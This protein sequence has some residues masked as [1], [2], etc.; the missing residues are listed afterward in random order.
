MSRRYTTAELDAMEAQAVEQGMNPQAAKESSETLTGGLE[1]GE[2]FGGGF[3][4]S[5]KRTLL[6][7][8]Q[9][10]EYLVGDD[11]G[12]EKVNAAIRTLEEH[13][14]LQTPAGKLGEAAGTA[15]QF[16]GPQAVGGVVAKVVPKAIVKG[17]QA[18]TGAPGSTGRAALQGATYEAAQPITPSDASNDEY[19]L[20]K[21][22]MVATGAGGGAVA[23]KVG[24]FLTREGMPIPP[25]RQGMV[26]EAERLGIP[27]TP[28]ERTGNK[29]LGELELGYRSKAGSAPLILAPGEKRQEMLN[30]AG[31]KSIGSTE[32]APTEA[33]LA[34]QRELANKGY[35]PIA[36]IPKMSPDLTYFDDLDKLAAKQMK[37]AGG[38]ADVAG[39][40][41]RLKAGSAKITGNDFLQELQTVR[42]M[43]YDAKKNGQSATASQL[44]DLG[45]LMEDFAERRVEK[46]AKAGKIASDAMDRLKQARTDLSK[47]H[48][49]E[50]AV[51]PVT[52]QMS[53]NKY[54]RKE[55]Q[56]NPASA[57]PSQSPV[58]KG[59][60]DVGAIARVMRQTNPNNSSLGYGGLMAGRE[61]ASA[62]QGPG[63]FLLKAGPIAKNYL[64]AKYY[65]KYGGKPSALGEHLTPTQ[66][67]YVR[68]LLPGVGF[69]T[70]E[71]VAD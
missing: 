58:S 15:A 30:T 22:G 50:E 44:R 61:V 13:P 20:G 18:V 5:L 65:M 64:A 12:R 29:T 39:I 9:A 45:S 36:S 34:Q 27:L 33:V 6:G 67:D 7:L 59:L 32:E 47:I 4:A 56:R 24:K 25:A 40:I 43:S 26:T 23:G 68:R 19:L 11:A 63:S 21:T 46:L 35:E 57:G 62:T 66:N 37:R 70:K 14:A 17:V 1:S 60:E 16:M 49:I 31:A 41:K 8:E 38:S 3:G 28:Y 51:D 42:N 2:D 53:A 10:K 71:G 55:F 52:G 48:A 69:A 54:L